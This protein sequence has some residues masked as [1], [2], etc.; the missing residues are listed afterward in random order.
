[1]PG[2]SVSETVRLRDIELATDCV[3]SLQERHHKRLFNMSE[4]EKGVAAPGA[5]SSYVTASVSG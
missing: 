4:E 5:E 2:V 1:M 3:L